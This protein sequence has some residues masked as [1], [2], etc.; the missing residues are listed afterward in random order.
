[1]WYINWYCDKIKPNV[2]FW[3]DIL[4]INTALQIAVKWIVIL[5]IKIMTKKTFEY[6]Y[7]VF[8]L[9]IKC[10]YIILRGC[11]QK[12]LIHHRAVIL[13]YKWNSNE[14]QPSQ[15]ISCT[16]LQKW[17]VRLTCIDTLCSQVV[18]ILYWNS[19]GREFF[20]IV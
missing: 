19:V 13:L 7:G 6:F 1:M 15:L 10:I 11:K 18:G 17:S 5:D 2:S 12:I 4:V 20:N 3:M 16:W 8:N 9:N 14:Q